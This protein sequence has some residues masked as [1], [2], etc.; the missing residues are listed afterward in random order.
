MVQHHDR[1][2]EEHFKAHIPKAGDQK[3]HFTLQT[4]QISEND[5]WFQKKLPRGHKRTV[6]I[7]LLAAYSDVSSF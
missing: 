5:F 7:T 6:L 2:N 1:R 3:G 4:W